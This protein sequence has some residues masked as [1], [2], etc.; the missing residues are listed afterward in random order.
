MYVNNKTPI[1]LNK[2]L[3]DSLFF[4]PSVYLILIEKYVFQISNL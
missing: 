2:L 1:L 4:I 3:I